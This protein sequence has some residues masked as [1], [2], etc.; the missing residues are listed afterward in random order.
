MRIKKG[1]N[2]LLTVSLNADELEAIESTITSLE[3][4]I[5]NIDD[6]WEDF[7]TENDIGDGDYSVEFLSDV[8]DFLSNIAS[9]TTQYKGR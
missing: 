4:I 3:L 6:E 7:V 2:N 1:K 5:D 9:K 8:I